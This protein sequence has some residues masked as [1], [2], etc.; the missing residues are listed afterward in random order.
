MRRTIRSSERNP[1]TI[2]EHGDVYINDENGE[3]L[4]NGHPVDLTRTEYQLLRYLL[5]HANQLVSKDE[6]L[7]DVW[8]YESSGNANLVELAVGRLRKKI[9]EEP[10][11]PKRLVTVRGF[12]YK[13]LGVEPRP[14]PAE[15]AG[16]R[17]MNL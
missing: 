7:N 17:G 4:V 2:M 10:A 9:E 11:Q 12:G 13:L 8:G 16:Y 1:F 5:T 6:L 15:A 3:V 14:N